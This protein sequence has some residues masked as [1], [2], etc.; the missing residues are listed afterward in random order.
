MRS[1][2]LGLII[3]A[4]AV[5]AFA[6]TNASVEL[7]LGSAKQTSKFE[8]EEFSSS[9]DVSLGLRASIALNSNIAGE[10]SYQNFGEI[11]DSYIDVWGDTITDKVST[12]AVTAGVKGILPL[13]DKVSLN[14]RLGIARWDLEV[15]QTDSAFPGMTFKYS[16]KGT[17]FYYGVGAQLKV[18]DK[19]SLGAEY[20]VTPM[21]V[22]IESDKIDHEVKNLAVSIGYSF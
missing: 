11:N 5:P 8:G 16:D 10:F 13:N 14:A 17:D 22:S 4:V 21:D 6:Q 7:L 20:T 18:N 15:K 9:D 2:L 3:S 19:I 12:T 1:V